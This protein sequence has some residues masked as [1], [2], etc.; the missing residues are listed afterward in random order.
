MT[1]AYNNVL[2]TGVTNN[3]FRRVQEHKSGQGSAFTAKYHVVKL[4]YFETGSDV[5]QA[6]LRE[7]QIKTGSRQ[8]KIDLIEK[9]NPDWK[10][11]YDEYFGSF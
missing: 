3:L 2:Y 9:M 4:V 1:N 7:K 10:D 11:L 8:N 5:K 6:I